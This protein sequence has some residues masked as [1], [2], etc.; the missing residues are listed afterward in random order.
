MLQ[1]GWFLKSDSVRGKEIADK[2]AVMARA[3]A[4]ERIRWEGSGFPKTNPTYPLVPNPTVC[5]N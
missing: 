1:Y 2:A 3:K 4:P 5:L